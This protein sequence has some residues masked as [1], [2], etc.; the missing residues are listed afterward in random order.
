[1]DEQFVQ[2]VVGG[3][4]NRHKD[5]TLDKK[6]I[7]T[8]SVEIVANIDRATQFTNVLSMQKSIDNP[9]DITMWK[10]Y[11]HKVNKTRKNI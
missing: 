3:V 5:Q 4:L 1:M 10:G 8:L 11:E 9:L 7:A 2:G 6:R